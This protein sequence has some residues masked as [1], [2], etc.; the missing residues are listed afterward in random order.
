MELQEHKKAVIENKEFGGD[1][2]TEDLS[3]RELSRLFAVDVVFADVSFKQ[4]DFSRCYFRNCRFIRCNFTGANIKESNFKGSQFE[5][6]DFRYSTWEKT[7]LDEHFLD[8]CLPSEENLARDLARSLRVNF[9]QVGNYEAVNKA[10][11]IEVSLTG[12]H[13]YN[14]AYSRQSYYRAKYKGWSRLVHAIKHAHWKALDLLWGNGESITCVARSGFAVIVIAAL[15]IL[16]DHSQL[17]FLSAFWVAFTSFWGIQSGVNLADTY[18]VA[19]TVVRFILFGLFMAIL[20]K[21]LSR[22]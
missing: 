18:M 4:C 12:Q 15:F 16:R 19:L 10:A 5:E 11:S 13:L 20:V 2:Q 8:T 6:C 7:L 14:A 3:M 17:L 22:R 21:R 1:V 9:S